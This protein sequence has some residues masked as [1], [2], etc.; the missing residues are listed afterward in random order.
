MNICLVRFIVSIMIHDKEKSVNKLQIK[1]EIE[2]KDE[3]WIL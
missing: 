3:I 2:N 1:L